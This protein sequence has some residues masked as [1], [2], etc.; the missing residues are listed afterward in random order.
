MYCPLAHQ[1]W[2]G[3]G[4]F[5]HS[6][7]AIDFAGGI[8]VHISSGFSGLVTALVVGKRIGYPCIPKAPHSL[9]L[10]HIGGAL[11]WVGWFGRV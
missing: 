8:V 10:T 5:L 9:V 1:V 7:G 4:A 6:L 3:D 2:S 11:L